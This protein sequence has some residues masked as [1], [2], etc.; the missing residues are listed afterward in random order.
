[1]NACVFVDKFPLFPDSTRIHRLSKTSEPLLVQIHP[2]YTGATD[3][4]RFAVDGSPLEQIS[5]RASGNA[6]RVASYFSSHNFSWS[7]HPALL[8]LLSSSFPLRPSIVERRTL[9]YARHSANPLV[10]ALPTSRLPG[11]TPFS[12]A[13]KY[14]VL[15]HVWT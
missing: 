13:Q 14:G 10:S 12:T 5:S 2:V 3:C 1:M 9:R 6:P 8:G 15:L 4:R 11:F 7:L